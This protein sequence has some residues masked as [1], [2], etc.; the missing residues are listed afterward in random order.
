[1]KIYLR[2]FSC[3][4]PQSLLSSNS[5][6]AIPPLINQIMKTY[7]IVPSGSGKIAAALCQLCAQ[8]QIGEPLVRSGASQS[9]VALFAARFAELSFAGQATV[10]QVANGFELLSVCN[11]SALKQAL[12][13]CELFAEEPAI[14][15]YG[16]AEKAKDKAGNL[17]AI[18]VASYWK[19]QGGGKAS[20]NLDV[21]GLAIKA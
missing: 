15:H 5:Q 3:Y 7:K 2:S 6:R 9:A 4:C 11:S 10:E 20:P 14:A 12:A 19:Q 18:S 1:M 13:D 17:L 16:S 8:G 21:L